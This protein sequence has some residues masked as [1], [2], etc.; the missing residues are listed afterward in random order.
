MSFHPNRVFGSVLPSA[1]S[2]HVITQDGT[3]NILA[4]GCKYCVG[5][6]SS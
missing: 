3:L 2:H 6:E 4:L 1:F 5:S